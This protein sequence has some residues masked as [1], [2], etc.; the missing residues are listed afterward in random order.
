MKWMEAVK[1]EIIAN[2]YDVGYFSL[3]EFYGSSLED[4]QGMFPH[5][6]TCRATI[7]RTLQELRDTGFLEF[8]SKGTY[9][10]LSAENDEWTKFVQRYHELASKPSYRITIIPSAHSLRP[11]F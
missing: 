6:N 10:V 9:C 4:L 11:C 2:G 5:N 3:Q 8:V 7:R 1:S